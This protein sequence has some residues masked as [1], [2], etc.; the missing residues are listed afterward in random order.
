MKDFGIFGLLLIKTNL[1]D[2]DFA[3]MRFYSW[4]TRIKRSVLQSTAEAR[5]RTLASCRAFFIL[6]NHPL[7]LLFFPVCPAT[8]PSGLSLDAI[9]WPFKSEQR[10]CGGH[11]LRWCSIPPGSGIPALEVSLWVR[12]GFASNDLLLMNL[13]RQMQLGDTPHIRLYE[14]SA[15]HPACPLLLAHSGP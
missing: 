7:P 3:E 1:L 9:C 6:W 13:I 15:F 10:S 11:P 8:H 2:L 5:H 4:L 14:D 12:D